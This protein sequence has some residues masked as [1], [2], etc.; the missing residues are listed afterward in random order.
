M[1]VSSPSMSPQG[2]LGVL[3]LGLGGNVSQGILKAVH[4]SGLQCRVVGAC[5]NPLGAGLFAVDRSYVSPPAADPGF[6]DWLLD[7]CR[8]ESIDCVLSGVEPVL[9]VLAG[10]AA[11]LRRETEAVAV[12]S[13]PEQ[14]RIGQDKLETCGW[15]QRQGLNHPLF[16]DPANSASVEALLDRTG[17]PVV[18]KPRQGN[19]SRGLVL[20]ADRRELEA[21]LGRG[22][23]VLEQYL[24]DPEEEYTV[25]CFS[26]SAGTVRGCIA[27]RRKLTGGTTSEVVVGDF[28]E[29]RA[30]AARVAAALRPMGPC[31]VQMRTHDGRPTTFEVNVRFSG[32]TPIRAH[33]GFNDVE[34]AI[35]HYVAGEPAV[36]LP[37]ITSGLAARYWNEVYLDPGALARPLSEALDD[38]SRLATF[39]RA[40][41]GP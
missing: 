30:E 28:P 27:M 12:V 5:I 3:I 16:A 29:V 19:A 6:Q 25:G 10:L 39:S 14:L 36:D 1:P 34:A 22:D 2:D 9:E 41:E 37:D 4:L 17:F 15:L 8:S 24:G 18:A 35:A 20:L 7:V 21:Y 40:L 26:D 13:A 33:F 23:Y 38:P 31:N 11:D 32:S